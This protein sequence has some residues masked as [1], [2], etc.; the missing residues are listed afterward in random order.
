M[1]W[2]NIS[3][4]INRCSIDIHSIYRHCISPDKQ[5]GANKLLQQLHLPI[6]AAPKPMSTAPIRYEQVGTINSCTSPT[7]NWNCHTGPALGGNISANLSSPVS[8]SADM[9]RDLWSCAVNIAWGRIWVT[10]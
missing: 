7:F 4:V 2:Q 10:T 8:V 3:A 5:N 6:A 9:C 1:T